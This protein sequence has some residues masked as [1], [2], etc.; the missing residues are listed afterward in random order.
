MQ[1]LIAEDERVTR[2][3][4][5]RQLNQM[6]HDVIEAADGREAWELFQSHATPIV[7]CDWEMPEMNG[8]D[9]VRR[10]RA[11]DKPGYV[12]IVMLTGRSKKDDVVAGIEAGAD[13]FVTKPFDRSELRARLNAGVRI[14][15]L[16]HSL[17][18]ANDR[19]RHELAVARELATAEHRKHEEPLS[20]V[21][22]RSYSW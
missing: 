9:L 15:E 4:L 6:G 16:E 8:V 11:A 3:Q 1:I 20:I 2:R 14:V 17:V 7:V 10:I 21:L 5:H 12:Y 19:L 18:T 22:V 13:D